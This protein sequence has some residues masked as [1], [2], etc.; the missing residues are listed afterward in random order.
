MI[1]LGADHGGY[2]M[3]E[4]IK[5]W[6]D[7]RGV[8]YVDCGALSFDHGDDYPSIA[9]AVAKKV[10]LQKKNRGIILCRSGNGVAIAANKTR[11]IRAAVCWNAPSARKSVEDDH[12]N[13]LSLPSDYVTTAEAKKI[14]RAWLDARPSTA[15][16]HVRRVRAINSLLK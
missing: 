16:R 5:K 4:D 2:A 3:K 14:V 6:L 9:D 10:A 1:Y 7:R 12:A 15:D 11:G 8:G 13:I